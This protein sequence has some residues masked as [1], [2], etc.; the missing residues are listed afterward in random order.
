MQPRH[1]H[2]PSTASRADKRSGGATTFSSTSWERSGL[3]AHAR[4]VRPSLRGALGFQGPAPACRSPS[5][6]HRSRAGRRRWPARANCRPG[7][8]YRSPSCTA[9]ASRPAPK[10]ESSGPRRARSARS[11]GPPPSGST[12]RF[13][14]PRRQRGANRAC[15]RRLSG[16]C[17]PRR[18][19]PRR[20]RTDAGTPRRHPRGRQRQR[21]RRA[22]KPRT[23]W[24]PPASSQSRSRGPGRDP[25]DPL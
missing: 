17:P 19:A 1:L 16:S 21:S 20:R 14:P 12:P 18:P 13:S 25:P 10:P 4:P 9:S 6:R 23:R 7:R 2:A 5:A 11:A 15:A 22:R 8:P 24:L 3:P